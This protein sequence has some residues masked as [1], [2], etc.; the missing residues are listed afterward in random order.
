MNMRGL[1]AATAC[2]IV[3]ALMTSGAPLATAQD[4]PKPAPDQK[5]EGAQAQPVTPGETPKKDEGAVK[6][7]APPAPSAK[8]LE[9]AAPAAPPKAAE[10][11]Q[12]AMPAKPEVKVSNIRFVTSEYGPAVAPPVFQPGE[13]ITL[14]YDVSQFQTDIDSKSNLSVLHVLKSA[15]DAKELA[16]NEFD[17]KTVCTQGPPII[18]SAKATLAT[19]TPPGKYHFEIKLV[20][21]LIARNGS[22]KGDFEVGPPKFAVVN[23]RFTADREGKVEMPP[24]FGLGQ[25]AYLQFNVLGLK[26][27]QNMARCGASAEAQG[28][29][30][31]YR[32]IFKAQPPPVPAEDGRAPA[33]PVTI[34]LNNS[35]PGK[36]QVNVEVHD[37]G[38]NA[39]VN[40][41][42][43]YEV[44]KSN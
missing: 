16:K 13:R 35:M 43:N 31:L 8:P 42:V 22:A 14:R 36:T 29:D 11:A 17:I 15:A 41:P 18:L 5:K 21:N 27:D 34:L 25:R 30:G 38:A 2:A 26:V 39:T 23:A 28:P 24:V 37:L 32:K 33:V 9:Q 19:G 12:P 44:L 10:P 3:L 6:A 40:L 7:P 1:C 20:D 4:A